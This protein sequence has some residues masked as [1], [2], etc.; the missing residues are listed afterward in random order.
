V[1]VPAPIPASE[2]SS[3]SIDS[4]D[5]TST[6]PDLKSTDPSSVMSQGLAGLGL[7][8]DSPPQPEANTSSISK[9]V[10]EETIPL[11]GQMSAQHARPGMSMTPSLFENAAKL[12]IQT[13]HSPYVI[14][15][16]LIEEMTS[17][18]PQG[19]YVYIFKSPARKLVKIG[20]ATDVNLRKKQIQTGCQLAYFDQVE[21]GSVY[22]KHPDR[23]AKL[24]H[25]ELENFRA[26][27]IC[28][29]H[30]H[31]ATREAVEQEHKEWFDVSE[32]V[33]LESVLLWSDFVDQAYTSEGALTENWARMLTLLPIPTSAEIDS[34]EKGLKSLEAGDA[35]EVKIHHELR[36]LRYRSWIKGQIW[37]SSRQAQSGTKGP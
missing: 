15:S 19:G 32:I 27:M 1:L 13:N 29:D 24:V 35:I 8:N 5:G 9:A 37:T 34:W 21:V 12:P 14:D 20:K 30:E 31:E 25:L 33:A 6:V 23:V 17:P 22:V 3:I 16:N 28:Q 7:T 36:A 10:I 4:E 26:R 11:E 2:P 18:I